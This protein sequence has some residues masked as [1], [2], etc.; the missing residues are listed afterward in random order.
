MARFGHSSEEGTEDRHRAARQPP[1]ATGPTPRQQRVLAHI[2]DSIEHRGYPPSMRDI[3]GTVGLTSTSSVAHQLK[4]PARCRWTSRDKFR[5]QPLRRRLL[6]IA[7]VIVLIGIANTLGLSV[8][9]RVT[10][11]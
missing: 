5:S 8:L 1:D 10:S 6:G 3:G 2:K 7:V 4:V 9:E 11:R